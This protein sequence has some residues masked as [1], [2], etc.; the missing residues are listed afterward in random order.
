MNK[1]AKKYQLLKC[2]NIYE[3]RII[4]ILVSFLFLEF[5]KEELLFQFHQ[6]GS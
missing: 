3:P 4:R 1:N 6:S 2:M 5:Y